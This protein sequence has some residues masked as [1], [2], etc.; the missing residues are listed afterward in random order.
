MT[1]P[2]DLASIKA[3]LLALVPVNQL[4][5]AEFELRMWSATLEADHLGD[6]HRYWRP[7]AV[8][9]DLLQAKL[10]EALAAPAEAPEPT[11]SRQARRGRADMLQAQYD[12]VLKQH[13]ELQERYD[14]LKE[15]Y[16]RLKEQHTALQH[17][18]DELLDD[19]RPRRP[20]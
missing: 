7:I 14:T 8:E 10:D 11:E 18:C 2:T 15:Q 20:S 13:Q 1:E 3:R 12:L 16:D 5:F 9:R 17:D 6:I 4:P 19:K